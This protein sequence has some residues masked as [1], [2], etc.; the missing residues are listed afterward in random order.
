V[1]EV[2]RCT[3]ERREVAATRV[4][5]SS[6]VD[7]RTGGEVTVRKQRRA[8]HD[9]KRSF[10]W[11]TSFVVGSLTVVR[12][13]VFYVVGGDR[14]K[15]HFDSSKGWLAVHNDAVMTVLFFVFGVNLTAKGIPPLT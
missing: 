14:A 1:E 5:S 2:P 15:A 6:D 3:S 11:S 12:P 9:G 7:P 13:V 8:L 10:H 4:K